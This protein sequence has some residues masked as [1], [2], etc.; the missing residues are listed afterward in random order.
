MSYGIS[1]HPCL[2][3]APAFF[4]GLGLKMSSFLNGIPVLRAVTTWWCLIITISIYWA[5]TLWPSTALHTPHTWIPS[6]P[7]NNSVSQAQRQ[8]PLFKKK[9]EAKRYSANHP[10]SDS[11]S[12]AEL[13][14]ESRSDREQSSCDTKQCF[15]I[16]FL[17]PQSPEDWTQG[18]WSHYYLKMHVDAFCSAQ[19]PL[20]LINFEGYHGKE[21]QR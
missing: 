13:G 8:Y 12:V 1:P 16:P 5:L 15:I 19:I 7:H 14:S 6:H 21:N 10:R 11:Q 9:T 2:E 18:K 3:M 17:T 4:V 20:K